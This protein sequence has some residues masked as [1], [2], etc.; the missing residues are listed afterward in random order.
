MKEARP[1]AGRRTTQAWLKKIYARPQPYL[2]QIIAILNDEQIVAVAPSFQAARDA[3]S[4]LNVASDAVTYFRVPHSLPEVCIPTL[5]L[6]S[7]IESLWLPLY[8]IELRG[9]KATIPRCEM[10]V[11]SGADISLLSLDV[12]REL[13]T[14]RRRR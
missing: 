12:G 1:P 3:V 6:R 10:L 8:P 13:E 5:R 14:S 11:V 7:L 9:P 4:K 2:G